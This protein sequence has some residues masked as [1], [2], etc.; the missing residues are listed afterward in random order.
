M[1]EQELVETIERAQLVYIAKVLGEKS[2]IGKEI[3][4]NPFRIGSD[5]WEAW[6]D[7]QYEITH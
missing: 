6:Q 1:S 3:R 2:Q 5:L 4:K 7:G